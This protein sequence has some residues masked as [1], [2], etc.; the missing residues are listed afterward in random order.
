MATARIDGIVAQDAPLAVIF[1]RGP[2]KR[3]Q[4]LIWN[5]ESDEVSAGQWIRG[6]VYARKCGLSPD[7]ELVCISIMD[8][9][10]ICRP[11]TFEPLAR[12]IGLSF[13]TG[14]N[15]LDRRSLDLFS[16]E[17]YTT[18]DIEPAP[19]KVQVTFTDPRTSSPYADV[20][21]ERRL[22]S[23]GWR[24]VQ[25]TEY[26]QLNPAREEQAGKLNQLVEHGYPQE[27]VGAI[28]SIWPRHPD[29]YGLVK[30]GFWEKPFP[31]GTLEWR[32]SIVETWQ[33]IGNGES[34]ERVR[35]VPERWRIIGADGAEV[36][37]FLMKDHDCQFLDV[38]SRGRVI[39]GDKGCLWAWERCPEGE[40]Q[41]I[42]DLNGNVFQDVA[43]PEWAKRWP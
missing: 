16:A 25:E 43:T 2:S 39:F 27:L 33:V 22:V 38:D 11:P 26:V 3:T 37:N 36:R 32:H 41:L 12:W 9:A 1:R 24:R 20:V 8:W 30:E 31:G 42:A 4:Q 15:W 10:M 13:G 7:G 34:L 40:P 14:G 23:Q 19:G 5:L 28:T 17:E 21:F 35:P 18:V 6:H 29:Q